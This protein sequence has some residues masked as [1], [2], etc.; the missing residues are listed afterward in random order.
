M[1]GRA[2]LPVVAILFFIALLLFCIRSSFGEVSV[3]RARHLSKQTS[4]V[5]VVSDSI[6]E[7]S[8]AGTDQLTDECFEDEEGE[9]AMEEPEVVSSPSEDREVPLKQSSVQ[10]AMPPVDCTSPAPEVPA[11]AVVRGEEEEDEVDIGRVQ[12]KKRRK[13]I[14]QLSHPEAEAIRAKIAKHHSNELFLL[15]FTCCMVVVLWHHPLMLLLLAP[16]SLWCTMKKLS[17]KSSIIFRYAKFLRTTKDS[18]I[19]WIVMHFAFVFPQPLPTLYNL[20]VRLDKWLLDLSRELVGRLVS[21]CMIVSLL[22]GSVGV[23]I[24]LV[25]QIQLEV[26]N[27]VGLTVHVLNSSVANSTWIQ[28]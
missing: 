28:R 26:T 6:M 3:P 10:F 8:L 16:V 20:Y 22:I 23:S 9:L 19:S 18:V 15:L 1:L 27:A 17:A 5:D 25:A 21:A 4:F 2:G 12:L 13:A 14:R 24:L 7:L 11:T